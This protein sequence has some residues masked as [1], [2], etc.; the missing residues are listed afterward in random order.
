[1]KLPAHIDVLPGMRIIP[2]SD[3]YQVSVFSESGSFKYRNVDGTITSRL[4]HF[5]N[6]LCKPEEMGIF[7]LG[8]FNKL[9]KERLMDAQSNGKLEIVAITWETEVGLVLS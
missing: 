6:N 4:F 3:I 5:V 2:E 1:M 7:D 8:Y 9:V